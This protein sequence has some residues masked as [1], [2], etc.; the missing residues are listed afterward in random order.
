LGNHRK[1]EKKEEMRHL[2][3]SA[4]K[5]AKVLKGK[6]LCDEITERSFGLGGKTLRP[7][8]APG[9]RPTAR[10]GNARKPARG[11]RSFVILP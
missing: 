9:S 5:K 11:E 4:H 3:L 7:A 6:R 8:E 10:E 2:D 1:L